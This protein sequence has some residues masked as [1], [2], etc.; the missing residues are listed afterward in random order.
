MVIFL[1]CIRTI[2][3]LLYDLM[4]YL[5]LQQV[6]ELYNGCSVPFCYQVDLTVLSQL[7]KDNYNHP[8]LRCLNPQGKVLP[9]Q[10]VMLEWIF[11]PIEAK[12]YQVWETIDSPNLRIGYN[13]FVFQ[14][15]NSLW[16]ALWIKT[17]LSFFSRLKYQS[18][19]VM[20]ILFWLDLRDVELQS[21]HFVPRH[22][23]APQIWG[24]MSSVYRGD[25]SQNRR[26]QLFSSYS[27]L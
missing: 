19:L 23:L 22:L 8:L 10:T 4:F 27:F 13:F 26:E 18:V 9:G 1:F 6:Y 5:S 3:R 7:Q 14:R 17:C 20:G 16:S 24:H 21:R 15:S 12:M 25:L 2:V 11:S